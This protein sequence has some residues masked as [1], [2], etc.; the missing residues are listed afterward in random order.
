MGPRSTRH[1]CTSAQ[2]TQLY[3]PPTWTKSTILQQLCGTRKSSLVSTVPCRSA[4][5]FHPIVPYTSLHTPNAQNTPNSLHPHFSVTSLVSTHFCLCSLTFYLIPDEVASVWRQG[6]L[7]LK[8]LT[9]CFVSAPRR[10]HTVESN[11]LWFALTVSLTLTYWPFLHGSINK[12][13]TID[14]HQYDDFERC[15][16]I[17]QLFLGHSI[18]MVPAYIASSEQIK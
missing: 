14:Q 10:Y 2:I 12:M 15:F 3:L 9:Y 16:D 7:I 13:K 11:I 18:N 4:F 8:I 5:P 1:T 17:M 6:K